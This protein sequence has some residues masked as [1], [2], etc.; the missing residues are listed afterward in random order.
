MPIIIAGIT[1]AGAIGKAIIDLFATKDT[2]KTKR[3]VAGL[4]LAGVAVT[5]IALVASKK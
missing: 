4:G 1:F 2:N 5:G 3:I